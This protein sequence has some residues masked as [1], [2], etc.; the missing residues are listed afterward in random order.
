[1]FYAPRVDGFYRDAL[2]EGFARPGARRG[3]GDFEIAC[4]VPVLIAD[5]VETAA[6]AARALVQKKK[7]AALAPA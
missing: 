2:A 6:D 5:D 1:M 3:A 7:V 4:L